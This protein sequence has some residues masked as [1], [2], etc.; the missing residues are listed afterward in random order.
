MRQRRY[1]I[2]N[3]TEKKIQAEQKSL[4]KSVHGFVGFADPIT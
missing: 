1:A 4:K 3:C 2:A